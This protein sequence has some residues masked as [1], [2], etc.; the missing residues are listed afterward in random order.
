MPGRRLSATTFSRERK[1]VVSIKSNGKPLRAHLDKCQ[2]DI[3]I[4]G[5]AEAQLQA[6]EIAIHR[7]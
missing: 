7:A 3:R 4:F 2:R 1:N 6:I 5:E